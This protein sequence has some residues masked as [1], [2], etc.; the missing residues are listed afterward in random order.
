MS[1]N[2]V[3]LL[4]FSIICIMAFPLALQFMVNSRVRGRHLCFIIEK[5]RPLKAKL[6]KLIKDDFVE[7]GKD[8]WILDQE[9]MKPVD[10]PLMWPKILAGFQK[11]VWA[12]L[13]MRG[14]VDPLDW[15]NPPVGVLSSK[16]LP[17]ILDPHWLVNL[18][19]GMREEGKAPKG[20]RMLLY[21]A[22]GASVI[23]L[24]LLFYV[25]T[26]IGG[27]QQ[28]LEAFLR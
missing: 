2:V 12:S 24:V 4:I 26:K 18:V 22:V 9:L 5:G 19:Q 11:G 17:A 20:E 21:L 16:E 27:I 15:E 3:I 23:C 6:L 8:H 25:I 14:R 1:A 28:A 10:Y 7:D 13:V